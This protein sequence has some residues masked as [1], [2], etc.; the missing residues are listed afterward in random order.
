MKELD[1]GYSEGH[2]RLLLRL[3][4]TVR[5]EV[6]DT[7]PISKWRGGPAALSEDA[8]AEIVVVVSQ[9]LVASGQ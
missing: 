3:P 4:V 2:D 9:A 6:G 8:D 1:L 7:S 5:H